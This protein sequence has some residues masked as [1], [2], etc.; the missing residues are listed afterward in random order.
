M[1]VAA[2]AA[3]DR[4]YSPQVNDDELARSR[5]RLRRRGGLVGLPVLLVGVTLLVSDWGRDGLGMALVTLA[6]GTFVGSFV[7]SLW[8]YPRPLR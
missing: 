1:R 7:I 8:V 2:P 5:T 3:K 4:P 6:N